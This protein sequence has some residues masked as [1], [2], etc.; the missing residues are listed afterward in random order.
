MKRGGGDIPEYTSDGLTPY[1][2]RCTI[3]SGG[4]RVVNGIV[5]VDV[6]V[7]TTINMRNEWGFLA[8]FP[9]V[10]SSTGIVAVTSVSNDS[11]LTWAGS[12]GIINLQFLYDTGGDK[13]AGTVVHFVNHY[14]LS[15]S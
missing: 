2:N 6:T 8:G 10:R 4:Y 13:P 5:D 9:G 3:V 14:P 11:R 15:E 7:Q 1:L 12:E